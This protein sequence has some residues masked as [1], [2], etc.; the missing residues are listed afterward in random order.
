[1]LNSESIWGRVDS[2]TFYRSTINRFS[3]GCINSMVVHL[4]RER[5]RRVFPALGP[6]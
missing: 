2:R 1:M 6:D 5:K 4:D 3:G